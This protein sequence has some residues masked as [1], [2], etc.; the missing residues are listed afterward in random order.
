MEVLAVGAETVSANRVAALFDRRNRLAQSRRSLAR[1]QHGASLPPAG[2][3]PGVPAHGLRELVGLLL[4]SV[5]DINTATHHRQDQDHE[6]EQHADKDF[7][8]SA[9]SRRSKRNRSGY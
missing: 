9:A 7:H 2:I 1:G 3:G 5:A 4:D 6:E 8:T